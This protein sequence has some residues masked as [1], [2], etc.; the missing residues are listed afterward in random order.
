MRPI[1][2]TLSDAS[3][4]AKN[5]NP[6]VLDYFGDP[7]VSLQVDIT[8][9]VNYTVQQTLD[10]VNDPTATINWFNHPD[11][12]LVS[13]AVTR[14]GNYAFVPAAVRLVLNSGTGSAT[15]IVLQAGMRN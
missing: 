14:Q 8:G 5:S 12:N 4:G 6:I 10:N 9:T 13:Q 7:A 11:S 2:V 3:A 1:S 15:L